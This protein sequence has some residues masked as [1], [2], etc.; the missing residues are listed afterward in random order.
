[1]LSDS[2]IEKVLST[3]QMRKKYEIFNNPPKTVQHVTCCTTVEKPDY[4]KIREHLNNLP[5]NLK[6]KFIQDFET[7]CLS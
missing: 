2:A 5:E 4:N 3:E 6:I 7:F 1:M